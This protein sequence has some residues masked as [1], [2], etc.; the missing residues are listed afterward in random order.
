MRSSGVSLS[1]TRTWC[2][3]EV[4]P[5]S[6]M[7]R[8]AMARTPGSERPARGNRGAPCACVAGSY[9]RQWSLAPCSSRWRLASAKTTP[10]RSRG[11]A[12][13][14]RSCTTRSLR[15]LLA[16]GCVCS[17][18][19][20]SSRSPPDPDRKPP[21][22]GM[23][24]LISGLSLAQWQPGLRVLLSTRKLPAGVSGAHACAC[25]T[26]L[27][28]SHLQCALQLYNAILSRKAHPRRLP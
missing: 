24:Y 20:S 16:S 22:F 6:P 7:N 28:D 15:S 10:R 25:N 8:I 17:S 21:K 14:R 2:I 11:D 4:R 18:G 9:I 13:C 27:S 3:F 1:L 26:V 23:H 12:D 19:S 5:H